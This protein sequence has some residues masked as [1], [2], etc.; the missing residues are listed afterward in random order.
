[1]KQRLPYIGG[2]ALCLVCL[3]LAYVF[4]TTG[5]RLH[6]RPLFIALVGLPVCLYKIFRPGGG[7]GNNP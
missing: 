5:Q 4:K 6:F 2:L 7:D 1:M 3:Y